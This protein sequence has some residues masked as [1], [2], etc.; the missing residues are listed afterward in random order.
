MWTFK[1]I[2]TRAKKAV[3][4]RYL[5]TVIASLVLAVALT[6]AGAVFCCGFRFIATPEVSAAF[7]RV[8]LETATES[9][10]LAFFRAM[11]PVL[12]RI[13]LIGGA[14]AILLKVLLLNP[15][16]L[17]CRRYFL[18]NRFSDPADP[19]SRATLEDLTF[20]F[21]GNYKNTVWTLFRADLSVAL[22]SLLLVFPG[23][24]R[25]YAYRMVP[26]ILAEDPGTPPKDALSRSEEMM[27]G[28][29]GRTFLL[30]LSF[31]GWWLLCCCTLGLAQILFV[32][33]Y[34]EAVR[35]EQF[36]VLKEADMDATVATEQWSEKD[37]G[38]GTRAE[39]QENLTWSEEAE[40]KDRERREEALAAGKKAAA[41]RENPFDDPALDAE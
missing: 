9:D 8:M 27:R 36:C 15:L 37:E 6:G 5:G 16:A 14:V 38:D 28:Q 4:A 12:A 18:V 35:A 32:C 26:Y 17:G 20:G 21:R 3:R 2:K 11:G 40:R 33:P 41:D 25:A 29:K 1:Q 7:D 23:V 19:S 13:L 22:H 31:I 39:W 24:M 34:Y 10:L 30:D